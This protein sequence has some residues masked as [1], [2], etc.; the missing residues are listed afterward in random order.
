MEGKDYDFLEYS[1]NTVKRMS[2]GRVAS[3]PENTKLD[4]D[5]QTYF[6][7]KQ[8]KL[9]HLSRLAVHW[10]IKWV[11]ILNS[12]FAMGDFGNIRNFFSDSRRHSRL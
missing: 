10:C 4:I 6:R 1:T 2:E 8:I 7:V 3:N 11:R 5:E 9:H 12:I